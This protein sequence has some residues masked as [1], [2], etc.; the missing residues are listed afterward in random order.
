[1]SESNFDVKGMKVVGLCM[2][3]AEWLCQD[4]GQGWRMWKH[5]G[6]DIEENVRESK[7]GLHKGLPR[8]P[9]SQEHTF[10]GE[11]SF[12]LYNLFIYFFPK[13]LD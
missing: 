1:M 12:L 9:E 4:R 5:L 8:S 7:L 2:A 10:V 6:T 11:P 13:V 3:A